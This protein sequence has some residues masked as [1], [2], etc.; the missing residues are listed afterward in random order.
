[1]ARDERR[2]RVLKTDTPAGSTIYSFAC[3]DWRM[4][5]VGPAR[6]D[7]LLDAPATQ[8]RFA[9]DEYMPYWA[10]P[11]PAGCM[12]AEYVFTRDPA[13]PRGRALEIGAGLGLVSIAAVKAGWN[14]VCSDYDE[15]ALAYCR[16]NAERNGVRLAGFEVLDWRCPILGRRRFD[17]LLAAD[18]LYEARHHPPIAELIVTALRPTGVALIC[19]PN[20]SVAASF[21]GALRD[22]GLTY[23]SI[24]V[25]TD[26]TADRRVE[27]VIY[28]IQKR[29]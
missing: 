17:R 10:Q 6:P 22:R 21:R 8:R 11:W 14:V 23:E 26:Q 24:A 12:L 28:R 19:D 1:M 15:E 16:L 18:V 5:F 3:G 29:G 20:R 25:S 7:D 4:E 2:H 9:R 27:G 13:P